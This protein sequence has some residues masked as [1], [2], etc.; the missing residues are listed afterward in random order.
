VSDRLSEPVVT[1]CRVYI[2][3]LERWL[4]GLCHYVERSNG[5][6]VTIPR[7][8][9]ADDEVTWA[10]E[11]FGDY[12][13]QSLDWLIPDDTPFG[14]R[15][16]FERIQ[17]EPTAF[18]RALQQ[19]LAWPFPPDVM[20][21]ITREALREY[22]EHYQGDPLVSGM[23]VERPYWR[24][25][26]AQVVSRYAYAIPYLALSGIRL[27]IHSISHPYK[28]MRLAERETAAVTLDDR[29]VHFGEQVIGGAS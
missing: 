19:V 22:I 24:P 26:G 11:A 14:N 28:A 4:P 9:L 25:P 10:N 1:A 29:F 20:L 18:T 5:T 6:A 2:E 7:E 13:F 15:A 12:G 27:D 21:H 16:K 23:D 8:I 17:A 3:A